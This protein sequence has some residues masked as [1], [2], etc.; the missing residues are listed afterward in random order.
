MRPALRIVGFIFVGLALLILGVDIWRWLT[1]KS[2]AFRPL[3]QVWYDLS[4]GS[5]NLIQA[6]IERYLWS[7]LYDPLL[8]TLLQQKA[9]LVLA[10]F[11]LLLLWAGRW[12]HLRR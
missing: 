5:L 6:V 4:P 12:K 1:T 9:S 8:L 11:G 10:V 3:G 2:F 7:P